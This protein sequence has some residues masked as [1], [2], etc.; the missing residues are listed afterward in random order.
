MNL[1]SFA[2]PLGDREVH[3]IAKSIAT[4]TWNNMSPE[5]FKLWADNRRA[6]SIRVRSARSEVRAERIREIAFMFPHLTQREIANTV[7]LSVG[8]VNQALKNR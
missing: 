7:G 6:K 4:W 5:G 8:K 2:V 1:E 3:H